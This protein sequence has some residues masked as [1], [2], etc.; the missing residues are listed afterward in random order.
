M[1]FKRQIALPVDA[2]TLFD[3]HARPGALQRLLPPWDRVDLVDSVGEL[4]DRRL[5]MRMHMGLL[6]ILWVAQHDGYIN[7]KQFRDTQERGPFARWIHTHL[8]EPQGAGSLL[9]DSIDYE[10]P[11]APFGRVANPLIVARLNRMFEFRHQRTAEDLARH[12]GTTPKRVAVTGATGLIGTQLCAFLETG[13]HRVDRLVRKDPKPGEIRWD[14]ARR[15]IDVKALEGVDAVIHLAGEN[16]GDRWTPERKKNV[17]QSRIDGTHTIADAVAQL[18]KKPLLLSA[19]AVGY[20]GDTGDTEADESAPNGKGFLAEVCKAWEESAD[21]ARKAGVRVVHP[22]IGVILSGAG[23]ALGQMRTPFSMGVGGPMGSGKQWMPWM[24]MDDA[25]GALHFLLDAGL[26][27]PV[28]VVTEPVRQADFAR[29][30]GKALGRPAFLP[31]PGFAV[32]TLFGEMGQGVL[33]EGQRAVPRRLRD[34][35]FKWLRTDLVEALRFEL[36]T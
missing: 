10:L 19:S 9:T 20:Y 6:K 33:L 12:A 29:A 8:T 28:N 14:P 15:S 24:A 2:Q 5:T 4:P 7:G 26:E 1:N 30:L 32:R 35:G 11:L 3:W 23:G 16:V 21:P 25:V 34:A 22:R 17:L 31:V 36:G 13:G 18:D 27:G